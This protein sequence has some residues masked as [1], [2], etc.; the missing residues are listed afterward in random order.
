[1][2]HLDILVA[3]VGSF[4]DGG[5]KTNSQMREPAALQGKQV[6]MSPTAIQVIKNNGA[7]YKPEDARQTA[8]TKDGLSRPDGADAE[9]AEVL[10]GEERALPT[11]NSPPPPEPSTDKRQAAIQHH[12]WL[13]VDT[14][15]ELTKA[16]VAYEA[17]PLSADHQN[18][19]P[20]FQD[21][22]RHLNGS[23]LYT[24]KMP[25]TIWDTAALHQRLAARYKKHTESERPL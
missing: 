17:E 14:M 10:D 15:E 21:V 24:R 1:M 7:Q 22:R 16:A 9:P 5:S 4:T 19:P 8:V 2:A 13:L 11:S 18:R 23:P 3:V 25:V 20:C 6:L 12:P